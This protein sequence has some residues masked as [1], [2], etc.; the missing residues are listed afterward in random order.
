MDACLWDSEI[1]DDFGGYYMA[2]KA[3]FFDLDGT[4]LPM[5][6]EL[7][8][9]TYLKY[10][11]VKM[12]PLGYES[13]KFMKAMWNGVGAMI[14]NDGTVT[15]EKRFWDV[16]C[17]VFGE[18]ALDDLPY[19]D[20][21]Y[22]TDFEK[23]KVT[24]GFNKKAKETIDI[25]KSRGYRVILATNPL[26]PS[27][28]TENRIRWAGLEPDDFELFTTYENSNFCKPNIKYYE[29]ILEKTGLKAQECIMVGNDVDD[30]M[31]VKEMGMGVFLLPACL[32][33]NSN[34]DISE[35]PNGDFDD[36][37]KFISEN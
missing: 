26:F 22:R 27:V 9:K 14:K 15:N 34:K 4:L 8:V 13:E 35:Y 24:C 12:A 31:V 19:F 30:D 1:T 32:I 37:L 2:V 28:A 3:I 36:L 5:D 11:A 16:F 6:Q 29:Q 10:L 18:K 21:F 17:G 7:F 23:A 33:N 20:E 25:L